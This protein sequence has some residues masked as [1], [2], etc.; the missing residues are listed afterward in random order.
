MNLKLDFS[1]LWRVILRRSAGRWGTRAPRTAMGFGMPVHEDG[2][3]LQKRTST[4]Y[5]PICYESV[6]TRLSPQAELT[7]RGEG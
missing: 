7:L 3:N 5:T 4:G 2:V 1:A 6:N